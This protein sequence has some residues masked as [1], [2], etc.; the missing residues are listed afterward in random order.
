MEMPVR[1]LHRNE[2]GRVPETPSEVLRTRMGQD[3]VR[4]MVDVNHKSGDFNLGV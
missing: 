4:A 1:Q 2:R 3:V